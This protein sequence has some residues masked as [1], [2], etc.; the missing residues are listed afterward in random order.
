MSC[1][2]YWWNYHYACRKSGKDVNEDIYSKYCSGYDYSDCPIY[3][4]NESTSGGCFLTSACVEA[5]GLS[6]D[7]HE[8]TV[9]RAF[10][11]GYMRSTP[12]GNADICKYYHIAPAIVEKIK[13]QPDAVTIFD[14]IYNELVLPCVALIE[15]GKLAQAH[16]QYRLYTERL[17]ALYL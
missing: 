1:P 16:T 9:L 2:Y 5:K 14:R 15:D 10:R 17:S 8:L 3:K 7:C 4:G 12:D 11:D 6:D 13:Q